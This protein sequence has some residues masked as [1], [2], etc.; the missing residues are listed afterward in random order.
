[1]HM[2]IKKNVK[3]YVKYR[4]LI[5]NKTLKRI[6]PKKFQKTIKGSILFEKKALKIRRVNLLKYYKG[7]LTVK[8]YDKFNDIKMSSFSERILKS[9]HLFVNKKIKIILTLR[10]LNKNV[11]QS[12]NQEKVKFLKE[13]LIKLKKY[14][15]NDFFKEGVNIMFMSTTQQTSNLL[16]QFTATQLSKLKRHNFFLKF[17]KTTLTTFKS[18]KFSNL[19]G[20]KIKIKGRL[21]G[22]PRAKHK[23][24]TIGNGVPA[25]TLNSNINYSES[26]SYTSNGTFG[27]K[28]WI[29]N[30]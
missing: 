7:F 3:N 30:N 16:A 12:L 15:Q 14:K 27:V 24:I 26:T 20:I 9:L 23:I 5:T 25:L 10:Q 1:M 21:N 22:A 13:N 6:I 2:K 4:T 11:Q 19:Q 28:V 8:N 18:S 17:L 29:C